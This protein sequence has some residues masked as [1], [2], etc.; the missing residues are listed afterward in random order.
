MRRS[1]SSPANVKEVCMMND[2]AVELRVLVR[3]TFGSL[4][5]LREQDVAPKEKKVKRKLES[6]VCDE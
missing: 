2:A 6:V 5:V 4:N 1:Q 3:Y